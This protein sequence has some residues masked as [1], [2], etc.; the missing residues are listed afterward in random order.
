[1][2][3]SEDYLNRLKQA[4]TA[5]LSGDPVPSDTVRPEVLES[6]QRSQK[7]RIQP[8]TTRPRIL[9]GK[10]LEQ[11]IEKNQ[12]LYDITAS[13]MDYLYQFVKGSGFM[14]LL[15]EKNGYILNTIGD[16]D[17]LKTARNQENPLVS[18]S[19]RSESA[20]G[21]NAVGTPLF[22]G[23]PIQL[24]AY[25]HYM[26]PATDWTCSGAPIIAGS[27][28]V[29]VLC[30][31]GK[32]DRVHLHTLGMVMAAS[33]AVSR[34]LHLRSA[35][36]AL[37]NLKNQL[38]LAVDSIHSG[39]VLLDNHYQ[40][41][42]VNSQALRAL[43][44]TEQE[45]LGHNY[46]KFF[47][48]ID[49]EHLKSNIIDQETTITGNKK[50]EK[51][52]ITVRSVRYA[53]YSGKDTF[54]ITFRKPEH[55]R[56]LVN[57][58]IGSDARYD[59]DNIIGACPAMER[60][61]E[62]AKL[63]ADSNTTV[64][65]TGESGTGKE[66]FAHSIHNNSP[67]AKGPFVAINCGAIPRELIE[68]EL[69]GYEAGAFTG[70]KKEGRAGKFELANN[71]TIFLDEI[72]DM[73]YDV[74]IQLLRVLQERSVTRIGGKKSIPL[75]IRVIAATNT[76]LEAAM[77]DHTFR[78]DLYYRL[79][80]FNLHIP[81]LRER[82]DDILLLAKYF[83]KK[84]R[85]PEYE[86]ITRIDPDVKQFFLSYPWPGNIRELENTMERVCI[87]TKDGRL[88]A[89]ALPVNMRN[90]LAG[91][92]QLSAGNTSVPQASCEKRSAAYELPT[93]PAMRS[94]KETEKELIL[95]HLSSS[96]GN[97]KKAAESLGISRRTLYRKLEK[98]HISPEELRK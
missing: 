87:L 37:T 58:V 54:L 59:F 84:Y 38:R 3:Y 70:A 85:N 71:G 25:E 31:S 39:T 50:S 62:L 76:N 15:A 68:S 55:V 16:E 81:P 28:I 91:V 47:P 75:N 2:M 27:E 35:Y 20:I 92:P 56:S 4:R 69:F 60:T 32:R 29:G 40:I 33:E 80:V 8:D 78:Q 67:C 64:L 82:G 65:I 74:Q 6:W 83:L 1:M 57:K 98:Y 52:Y 12:L 18:G 26:D 30:L 93:Q 10:A 34:E 19:C 41:S 43:D 72:G 89:Q 94:A 21:T 22:T 73:P 45:L 63:V 48:D 95:A 7:Y 11:Y 49:L 5:F 61:K 88:S 36:D 44:L 97:V 17:I 9:S 66:L 53:R 46:K 13:F 86:P 90:R 96:G 79:N 51:C 14:I 24:F 23:K 42:L 77:A